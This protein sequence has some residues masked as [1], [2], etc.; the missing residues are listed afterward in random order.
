M[1]YGW[2]VM[3]HLPYSP[4]LALIDG[5]LFDPLNPLKAE[6]N[7]ICH[8]LVLLGAHHILHISSIRVKQHLAGKQFAADDECRLLFLWLQH[9][10]LVYS[11][12]GYKT[13]CYV[14]RNV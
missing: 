13:W 12:P 14:G 2:V 4:N 3:D 8:L 1:A 6:L 11:V 5:Y 10:T 7:P 9:L